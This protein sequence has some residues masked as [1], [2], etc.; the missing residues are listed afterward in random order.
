MNRKIGITACCLVFMLFVLVSNTSAQVPEII[1][2]QGILSDADGTPLT[3]NY[4]LT[5]RIYDQQAGGTEIWNETHA[6]I[7]VS[8]GIF[9]IQLGS[10]TPFGAAV[11]FSI[12]YWLGVSINSGTELTPRTRFASVG[13]A[14][15]A[16]RVMERAI[17]AGMVAAFA[18]PTSPSGW[19]VCNGQAVSRT[20]YATLFAALGSMYGDGDGSTTFNLPDYRGYFLRSWDNGRGI[21]PE[22]ASRT[23]RGDGTSGD[24]VGTKQNDAFES[25]RH[26]F[27]VGLENDNQHRHPRTTNQIALTSDNTRRYL[28][29]TLAGAH[30]IIALTGGNE[31]RPQN[32]SVLYCIKY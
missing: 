19:L 1:S 11:D 32:I 21:D 22:A 18:M 30:D 16:K 14:L 4:D 12:P 8:D 20:T 6:G 7:A 9:N 29:S 13:T 2:Y 25:H 26:D 17:P 5:V 24:N 28:Q 15:M 27:Y 23:D 3:G 10:V 31:T